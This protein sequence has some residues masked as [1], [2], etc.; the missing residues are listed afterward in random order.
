MNLAQRIILI[1][2]FLA[3]AAMTIFPPWVY[4]HNAPQ[5]KRIERPAGYHL[6]TQN[7][8]PQDITQMAKLFGLETGNWEAQL[9]FFSVRLDGTRL[10]IQV[11]LTLVLTVV[12]FFILK[13]RGM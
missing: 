3:I 2:A 8:T 6:I 4:I 5:Y 9:R 11:C 12:L 7:N 1:I 10:F 13:S